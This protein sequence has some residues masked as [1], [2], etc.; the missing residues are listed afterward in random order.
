MRR[1]RQLNLKASF[2][3]VSPLARHPL[4]CRHWLRQCSARENHQTQLPRLTSSF[5]LP[6]SLPSSITWLTMAD[7]VCIDVAVAQATQ[8]LQQLQQQQAALYSGMGAKYT[9]QYYPYH[10]DQVGH[11]QSRAMFSASI[12]RILLCG[13]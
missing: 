8:T 5:Q 9:P 3:H 6:I 11:H 7:G 4:A 10:P 1:C 12:N 2:A 13:L